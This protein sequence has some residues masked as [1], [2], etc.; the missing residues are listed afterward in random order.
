MK[1]RQLV[2]SQHDIKV[3]GNTQHIDSII[4]GKTILSKREM[5]VSEDFDFTMRNLQ[6]PYFSSP[7]SVSKFNNQR[8]SRLKNESRF[9]KNPE[10]ETKSPLEKLMYDIKGNTYKNTLLP[11]DTYKG[12]NTCSIGSCA[13]LSD[14]NDENDEVFK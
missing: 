7:T 4:G 13:D 10:R 5:N 11:K 9:K 8:F 14:T 12:Y 1:S 6:N 3:Y 2:N